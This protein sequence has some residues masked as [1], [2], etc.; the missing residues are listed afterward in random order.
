MLESCSSDD[1]EPTRPGTPPTDVTAYGLFGSME[2]CAGLQRLELLVPPGFVLRSSY[3]GWNELIGETVPADES[4]A[5]C[6][7]RRMFERPWL[8]HPHDSVQAALPHLDRAWLV[9]VEDFALEEPPGVPCIGLVV[10]EWQGSGSANGIA[11]G[12][13]AIHRRFEETSDL[14]VHCVEVPAV[15]AETLSVDS[16]V[17]GLRAIERDLDAVRHVLDHYRPERLLLFGGTCGAEVGPASWCRS[18]ESALAIVWLDAH[19][20]LNTPASSPSGHFHGMPLRTLLGDGPPSIVERCYAHFDADQVVLAGAR[21]LD[22]A[23]RAFVAASEVQWLRPDE[24]TPAG[25]LAAIARTGCHHCYV[26][27]DLDVLD[28]ARFPDVLVPTDGGLSPEELRAI[29]RAVIEHH[30]IRGASVVEY[31]DR[32]GGRLD[33]AVG[34]VEMLAAAISP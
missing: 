15:A 25:V 29:L 18:R 9:G 26:H 11:D 1:E 19:A 3:H 2:A 5:E 24:T 20:D 6:A 28:P 21:D 33:D 8:E 34:L 16:G 14:P 12:A 22:P 30:S 32:G 31:F 13:R 23:E 17:L 7:L 27:V 4:A 10:P